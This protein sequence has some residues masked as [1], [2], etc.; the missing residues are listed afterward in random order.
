MTHKKKKA[1][2]EIYEKTFGNISASCKQTNI[3][4]QTFYD[5]KKKDELFAERE[6][7]IKE[8]LL[9]FAETQLYSAIRN[10]RTAELIFFLKTKG[11]E[12]GY[13]EQVTILT[14]ELPSGFDL[15]EI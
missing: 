11:R 4:R 6:S 12:R 15:E 3:S 8:G 14:D 1:F 13:S 2:L 5:W 7:E 9:D 10:G